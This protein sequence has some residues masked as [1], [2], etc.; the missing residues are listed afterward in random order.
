MS[1]V[2]FRRSIVGTC[3]LRN[4]IIH[5]VGEMR[6][7]VLLDDEFIDTANS[8]RAMGNRGEKG[9]RLHRRVFDAGWVGT[10]SRSPTIQTTTTSTTVEARTADSFLSEASDDGGDPFS[11]KWSTV[12]Y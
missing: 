10:A 4:R 12:N 11:L 8:D 1:S 2:R 3:P 6:S 7:T 9:T 5:R